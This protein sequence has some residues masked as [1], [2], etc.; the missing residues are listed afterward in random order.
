[1]NPPIPPP[2]SPM[3]RVMDGEAEH[4]ARMLVSPWER[5]PEGWLARRWAAGHNAAI[6]GL[7]VAWIVCH[8]FDARGTCARGEMMDDPDGR[9]RRAH[10]DLCLQSLHARL[11]DGDVWAS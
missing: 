1:M 4:R 7:H 2:V 10:C 3:Y 11:V 9:R 5:T 8:E 6:V